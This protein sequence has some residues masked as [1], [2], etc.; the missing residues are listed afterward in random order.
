M[1]ILKE[2]VRI[3]STI[4]EKGSKIKVVENGGKYACIMI[5]C[6]KQP[7]SSVLFDIHQDIPEENIYSHFPLIN[8]TFVVHDENENEINKGEVTGNNE[9]LGEDLGYEEHPHI[10]VAYGLHNDTDLLLI[11]SEINKAT[12]SFLIKDGT[13]DI[14][15]NVEHG[16]CDCLV[17]RI[18]E[19]PWELATIRKWILEKFENTQTYSEY[20]PHITLAYIKKGTC[21][22]F[23]GRT[24][25]LNL[26]ISTKDFIYSLK[27]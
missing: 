24:V 20:K 21:R 12:G 17:I 15:E 13:I 18:N 11:Q 14:F 9:E 26:D 4:F 1:I 6:D 27:H 8:Y 7:T 10:T 2:S 3:G 25:E 23:K 16:E 22:E 5:N 19:I